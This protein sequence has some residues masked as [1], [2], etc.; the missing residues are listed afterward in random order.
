MRC[1]AMEQEAIDAAVAIQMF[2]AVHQTNN[3]NTA[4]VARRMPTSL[5]G[6]FGSLVMYN[7]DKVWVLSPNTFKPVHDKENKGILPKHLSLLVRVPCVMPPGLRSTFTGGAALVAPPKRP[8][9]A[10]P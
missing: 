7:L 2:F 5:P 10:R 4:H 6:K 9:P 3:N 1:F 8:F